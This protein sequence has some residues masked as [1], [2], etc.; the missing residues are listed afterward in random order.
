MTGQTAENWIFTVEREGEGQRADVYLAANLPSLSRSRIQSLMKSGDILL[1]GKVARSGKKLEEGDRLYCGIPAPAQM[2]VEPCPMDLPIVYED[3]S[4][5][6]INKPQ[7]LVVH[8]APGSTEKTLVHG[9]LAHCGDLSGING[10]LRPGIVHRLDKDTSGLL[11]VAKTDKAHRA[12]AEQIQAGDMKRQYLAVVWGVIG[13]PAGI[14]DAPVGRDP[15]DRQKMA[16]IA[17]GKAAQTS[18]AV[19]DRLEDK[20][21]VQC[22]L[23]TG[24]TH[25][26]RVHMKFL[27]F[28]VVGDPKYGRRK[29]DP[30][31]PGQALHAWG[32]S[33][34]HPDDQKN[35]VFYACPPEG[36]CRFLVE[37][38][39]ENTLMRMEELSKFTDG[40]GL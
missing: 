21:V 31:W 3:H 26:I 18:Y 13:E 2:T 16:V 34:R 39:A 29:D 10:V 40:M 30:R 23:H 33:F 8:P 35:Y 12:L 36:F 22:D 28:P 19:L 32:I 5:L 20:T 38:K 14:V 1:N 17:G 27:G 25:Q 9:L 4:L 11:V 7:G 6:V 24:R 15:K 37:E